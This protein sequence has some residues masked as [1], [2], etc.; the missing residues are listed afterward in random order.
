MLKRRDFPDWV[1][2]QVAF[3]DFGG[4]LF[5]TLAEFHFRLWRRVLYQKPWEMP[6]TKLR[7]RL[8]S[9][10]DLVSPWILACP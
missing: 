10:T 1:R 5:P 8:N 2:V 7:E 9:G 3:S 4:I 6:K